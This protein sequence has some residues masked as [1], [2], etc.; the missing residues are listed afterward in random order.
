MMIIKHIITCSN[1]DPPGKR[2]VFRWSSAIT[3]TMDHMSMALENGAP[4]TIS[5]ALE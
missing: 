5:G 2:G 4:R 1:S 3:Q